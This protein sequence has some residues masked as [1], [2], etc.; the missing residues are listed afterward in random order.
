MCFI[1]K[2]LDWVFTQEELRWLDDVMPEIHNRAKEDKEKEKEKEKEEELA[3]QNG[4]SDTSFNMNVVKVGINGTDSDICISDEMTK[5]SVW[6]H[7]IAN[8]SSPSLNSNS[9]SIKQPHKKHKSKSSG[10]AVSF[11]IDEEEKEHLLSDKKP[12]IEIV[13][14]PPSRDHSDN[15]ERDNKI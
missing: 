11:Y 4:T 8:E 6:K 15:E 10:Q 12:E 14:D 7:L 3:M 9:S 5:T 13:V 2:G 1:R